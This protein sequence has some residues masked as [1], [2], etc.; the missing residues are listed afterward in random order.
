MQKKQI[1]ASLEITEE[2]IRLLV[3]E[4]HMSRFNILRSDVQKCTGVKNRRIEKPQAVSAAIT[5]I[6]RNAEEALSVKIK[7]VILIMFIKVTYKSIK[8]L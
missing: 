8:I 3:A 2:E 7:S 6:I 4:Y 1:F 5:K